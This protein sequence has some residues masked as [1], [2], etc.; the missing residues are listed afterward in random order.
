MPPSLH[1][2]VSV[3]VDESHITE[4][5]N[6]AFFVAAERSASSCKII[7]PRARADNMRPFQLARI[8]SSR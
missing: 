2:W 8:L 4:R 5:K 7:D 3:W 6:D 1:R